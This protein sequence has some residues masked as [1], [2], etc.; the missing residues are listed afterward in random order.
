[1][2]NVIAVQKTLSEKQG[3]AEIREW[4]LVMLW[5]LQYCNRDL[6]L[7]AWWSYESEQNLLQLVQ[8]LKLCVDTFSVAYFFVHTFQ[9]VIVTH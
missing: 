1:V 4:C 5:I 6:H 3:D 7:R 9:H 2:E 8:L